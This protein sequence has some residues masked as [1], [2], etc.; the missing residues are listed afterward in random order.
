VFA[1]VG[2]DDDV[3]MRLLKETKEDM[4]VLELK[5]LEG[6][7]HWMIIEKPDEMYDILMEFLGRIRRS[8]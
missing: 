4:P 3:F 7:D 8:R 1:I 2:S 5:V 6:C